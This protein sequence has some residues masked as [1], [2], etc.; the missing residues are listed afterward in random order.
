MCFV[1]FVVSIPMH[2]IAAS[3][4][5]AVYD[6]VLLGR[7]HLSVPSVQ[8]WYSIY[9]LLFITPF[10][11]GWKLRWWP[12]NEFEWRW[13][14]PLIAITMLVGEYAY[15]AALRDPA[16]LVSVVISL[17]RGSTL[18]AFAGGIWL[19]HEQ[20]GR[21]KFLAVVGMLLGIPLTILG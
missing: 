18:V 13:G 5:S 2:W 4:L 11:L 7:M 21:Q 9:M 14:I 16:A 19:F 3:L 6:K 12:R 10:A 15:F 17:R 8:A 20:Q 1:C